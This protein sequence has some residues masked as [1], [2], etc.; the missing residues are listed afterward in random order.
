MSRRFYRH[1]GQ[2]WASRLEDQVPRGL[3]LWF[4]RSVLTGSMGCNLVTTRQS[5]AVC[6]GDF[7][8]Y[9]LSLLSVKQR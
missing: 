9:T 5:P 1:K 6:L 3:K 8:S 2:S 7:L 4:L